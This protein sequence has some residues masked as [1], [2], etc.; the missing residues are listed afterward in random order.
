MITRNKHEAPSP[1]LAEILAKAAGLL[2]SQEEAEKWLKRHATVTVPWA[3]MVTAHP[4]YVIPDGVHQ[5]EKGM[6]AFRA[7]IVAGVR[8]CP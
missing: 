6:A 1:K 2:G 5:T 3:S 4:E 8:Q 7:A